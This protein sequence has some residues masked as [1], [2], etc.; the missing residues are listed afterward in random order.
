MRKIYAAIAV[1]VTVAAGF[2]LLSGAASPRDATE[3]KVPKGVRQAATRSPEDALAMAESHTAIA[4]RSALARDARTMGR[5][6]NDV[7]A[8]LDAARPGIQKLRPAL[9]G[10]LTGLR[11]DLEILRA[12]KV[13]DTGALA[14]DIAA[15]FK[16]V[17]A[18]EAKVSAED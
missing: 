18:L 4:Y 6:L 9:S 1:A 14:A 5:Q 3:T 10:E 8:A 7:A 13:K 12:R 11:H 2:G 17:K 15:T 16:R